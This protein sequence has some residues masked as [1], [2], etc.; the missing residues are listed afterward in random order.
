MDYVF[1]IND[2]SGRRI[3]LSKERW[4]HITIKH[5]DMS[6]KLEDIKKTLIN[7]IL[8]VA[9]RYD[10]AMRNYFLYYRLEGDYLLV[11]VKYLNGEGFV[12]TAF[13]T[14]RINKR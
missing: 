10:D 14:E 13:M 4:S 11:S 1:E 3:H 12:A 8:I 2:K 5:K 7:P 9:H 6:D